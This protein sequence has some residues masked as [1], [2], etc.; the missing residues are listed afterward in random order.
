LSDDPKEHHV[1][2]SAAESP[3]V[4]VTSPEE[5]HDA[6]ALDHFIR[7]ARNGKHDCASGGARMAYPLALSIL[8]AAPR[9]DGLALDGAN[10][11]MQLAKMAPESAQ[12]FLDR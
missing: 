11:F 5:V 1:K 10:L 12:Q 4:A 3:V 7:L 9:L 8:E 6:R 2:S